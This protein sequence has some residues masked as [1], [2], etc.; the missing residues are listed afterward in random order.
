MRERSNPEEE[1][2]KETHRRVNNQGSTKEWNNQEAY[3]SHNTCR[4]YG[5]L[6]RS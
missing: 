3:R 6:N 1:K 4:D 2:K 5:D